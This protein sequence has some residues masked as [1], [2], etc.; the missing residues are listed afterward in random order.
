M[1]LVNGQEQKDS[2][3]QRSNTFINCGPLPNE[4][5]FMIL[6]MALKPPVPIPYPNIDLA[7]SENRTMSLQMARFN[8]NKFVQEFYSREHEIDCWL[9]WMVKYV[10]ENRL[11]L[12]WSLQENDMMYQ[13]ITRRILCYMK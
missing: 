8:Y 13:L 3:H 11:F 9:Y 1:S 5:L 12:N 2:S 6:E 4:L 7:R 10:K